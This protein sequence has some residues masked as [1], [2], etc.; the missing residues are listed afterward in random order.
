MPE[1]HPPVSLL[2]SLSVFYLYFL[3]YYELPLVK[4]A[5]RTDPVRQAIGSAL[6]TRS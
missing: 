2:H 3:L 6:W 4:T 5:I 1:K